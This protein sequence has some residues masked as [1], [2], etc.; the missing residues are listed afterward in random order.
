ME[1]R[2]ETPDCTKHRHI[3]TWKAAEMVSGYYRFVGEFD[4][5]IVQTPYREWRKVGRDRLPTMQL[6]RV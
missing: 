4:R 2:N 1:E 6:V 3:P 5:R